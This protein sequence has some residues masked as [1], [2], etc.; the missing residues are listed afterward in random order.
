MLI[1][2]FIVLFL[3]P[4]SINAQIDFKNNFLN[5]SLR[6]DFSIG[7]NNDNEIA[8]L[9]NLREEKF[10]GGN[11]NHLIDTRNS[12]DYRI[13][14]FTLSDR[15][16]YSKG[17]NSLF[18]EWQT[19]DEAKKLNKSFYHAMQI[20]FPK[21]EVRVNIDSRQKNGEFKTILDWNI[22]PEDYLIEKGVPYNYK[23][24]TVRYSGTSDKRLDLVFVA[25]GYTDK[26]MYKFREDVR[27][28]EKYIFEV[29][30]FSEFRYKT[31]IY[32]ILSPSEDSK[33][34]VP[35]KGVYN[36]TILNSS[37]Y[38]FNSPRYLTIKDTEK[39]FDIASLVPYDHVYVIV[40]TDIYGG[41]G[42]YNF[43]TSCASDSKYSEEIASHELGHGLI[44]LAD[45]YYGNN[46]EI[47]YYYTLDKEPWEA[48]ITTLVDFKSKWEKRVDAK[49]PIP[50]P[51]SN[52]YK[53]I[54]GA[55]EGGAYQS[56]G[57]YSPMLD[58]K[59]KSNNT[60]ILCPACQDA[61][62]NVIKEYLE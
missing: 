9:K 21:R 58:C 48:N 52:N 5:K 49:T 33:P 40:N 54:V 14:V 57:V 24:D 1:R 22:N 62:R 36:N 44:G 59:M 53:N 60:K 13:R 30:P 38:T 20:P 18:R 23:I 26:E 12:G 46:D 4:F 41:A 34:D 2:F 50:T 10:W 6:I 43:Y 56:K 37:F 29:K 51:R 15:L 61:T 17:F 8:F 45:E 32:A 19:T 25:E 55:F 35:G 27:R 7:G 3:L 39:M 31:N 28:F 11:H 42:F 16:I 47:S